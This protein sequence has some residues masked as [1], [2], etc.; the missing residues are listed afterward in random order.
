MLDSNFKWE[1]AMKR[2]F[3]AFIFIFLL[4][5]SINI[6][7][8]YQNV[9]N[10]SVMVH[11]Q[12]AEYTIYNGSLVYDG[13]ASFVTSPIPLSGDGL[14]W[15][16]AYQLHD[17]EIIGNVVVVNTTKYFHLQN[18][19]I[20]ANASGSGFFAQNSSHIKLETILIKNITASISL[21]NCS[22]IVYQN[23]ILAKIN[24]DHSKNISIE[25]C[26]IASFIAPSGNTVAINNSENVIIHN[27]TLYAYSST[28]IAIS[29]AAKNITVANSSLSG[30]L[31]ILEIHSNTSFITIE[32]N[33]IDGLYY[34]AIGCKYIRHINESLYDHHVWRSNHFFNVS[35]EF[36]F[37]SN[38][39]I[40]ELAAFIMEN[41]TINDK[42][43]MYFYNE[44]GK[45]IDSNV[46]T[47]VAINC[48]SLL[49]SNFSFAARNIPII[50]G[51]SN[52][53]SI[54]ASSFTFEGTRVPNFVLIATS[55]FTMFANT[56]V[57]TDLVTWIQC[58]NNNTISQFKNN[59]FNGGANVFAANPSLINATIAFN[60][61]Q[62]I[63]T[64]ILSCGS[65]TINTTFFG[66]TIA[67]VHLVDE[68]IAATTN[69]FDNGS[70]GNLWGDYLT[71][72][73]SAS[74]IDHYWDTP[75]II[76]FYGADYFP[77]ATNTAPFLSSPTNMEFEYRVPFY[78]VTWHVDDLTYF[79]VSGSL[80]YLFINSSA[81]GISGVWIPNSDIAIPINQEICGNYNYT[82]LVTDGE[83]FVEDS[84]IITILN[85]HPHVVNLNGST[86]IPYGQKIWIGWNVTDYKF[87]PNTNYSI[88]CDHQVIDHQ[89]WNIG[90]RQVYCQI[91]TT[92]SIGSHNFTLI[93][94]DGLGKQAQATII[95]TI[96][97]TKPIISSAPTILA[98]KVGVLQEIELSILDT[99]VNVSGASIQLL[100]NNTKTV[101]EQSL[102]TGQQII[103]FPIYFTTI[104]NREAYTIIVNDGLG[105]NATASL[106]ITAYNQIPILYT[107]MEEIVFTQGDGQHFID[108][109]V[110]DDSVVNGNYTIYNG[111]EVVEIGNWSANTTQ[112]SYNVTAL[113]AGRYEF[114]IQLYDGHN[115]VTNKVTVI[116]NV[117][118][119]GFDVVVAQTLTILGIVIISSIILYYHK[120]HPKLK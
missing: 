63:E 53:I 112:I 58:S 111:D 80:Y 89:L 59:V 85:D 68:T 35:V 54:N 117:S 19:T 44:S 20:N 29:N 30:W 9:D 13:D 86:N 87:I 107:N 66:N 39:T 22:D 82:L 17:Y 34:N 98:I 14:S 60:T 69:K 40:T 91:D 73:P 78:N 11:P 72:Y 7:E 36:D 114:V 50:I 5:V 104:C 93:L 49:L 12:R 6:K 106:R 119:N 55:N 27:S 41:N 57:T 71:R 79:N 31:T 115:V 10:Y 45:T 2:E 16:T 3:S 74:R 95:V 56:F 105:S 26:T 67:N 46:F 88:L 42:P 43:Y 18:C 96:T 37:I 97:N 38:T 83:Y 52:D 92:F 62:N 102:W 64:K 109:E 65:D 33:S 103:K 118:N 108:W 24:I 113:N 100:H 110:E 99:T 90:S 47:F 4:I 120:K 116:V 1:Y 77:I 101:K 61:F 84:V 76:P 81:T 48:T 75:Y 51:W 21:K 8:S 70:Y 94:D 28:T 15:E 25:N 32:N 23:V